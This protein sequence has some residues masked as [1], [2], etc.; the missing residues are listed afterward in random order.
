MD[1]K[2][3]AKNNFIT[4]DFHNMSLELTKENIS[5]ILITII[6]NLCDITSRALVFSDNQEDL[7]ISRHDLECL[8][9]TIVVMIEKCQDDLWVLSV[10]SKSESKIANLKT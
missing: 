5:N 7:G 6:P 3:N 4:E 9:E 1:L 10:N 2:I 8:K